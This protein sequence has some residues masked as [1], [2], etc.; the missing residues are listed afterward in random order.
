MMRMS[1]RGEWPLSRVSIDR[2]SEQVK[3]YRMPDEAN[4]E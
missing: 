3:E 1:L 2:M 4:D